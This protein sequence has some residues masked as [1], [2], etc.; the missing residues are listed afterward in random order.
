MKL[1]LDENLGTRCQELLRAAG[2]DV[3]TVADQQMTSV[4]DSVLI[5]ACATEGRALVTLDLD[6]SNPLLSHPTNTLALPSC[7]FPQNR[8]LI[9]SF[10]PWKPS[11]RHYSGKLSPADSGR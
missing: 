2:H 3:M 10:V 6:F 5:A 11:S 4:S 1:K 8:R 9:T 7:G